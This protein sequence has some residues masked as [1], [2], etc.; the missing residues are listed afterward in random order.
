LLT[1]GVNGQPG[2]YDEIPYFN[3]SNTAFQIS[4]NLQ[5]LPFVAAFN[6]SNMVAGQNVDITSG[7]LTLGGTT[8]T[9]ANTITLIPQAING[10]VESSSTSGS[11]TVYTVSLASY[12]L[13]PQLAV[14]PG[15]T[16]VL[17]DPSHV[18]V[19][20]DGNTQTLNTQPLAAGS[21]LRFSGLVFNDNGTLR[22]DCGQVSDGVAFSSQATSSA[23]S[24]V[25]QI[26]TVRRQEA[27]VLPQTITVTESH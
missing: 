15:Q 21:T 23:P 16:T 17:H 20:V 24:E 4:G 2:Q 10:T 18:Q 12:D 26:R 6:A 19:Y 8:Y 27:G 5:K 7:V 3:F 1:D 14:Q 9:P 22:M 11:F 25:G 13:F